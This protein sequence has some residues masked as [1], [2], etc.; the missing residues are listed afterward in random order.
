VQIRNVRCESAHA[1]MLKIVLASLHMSN[2]PD[3]RKIVKFDEEVLSENGAF[4]SPALR[5]CV[6]GAVLK[7]PLAGAPVGTDLAPLVDISVALGEALTRRALA[8]L[9]EAGELRAYS[10]AAIVGTAGDL[11][12]GAAM[13]HARIGMAMRSTIK[14][15]R[16]LIP[17]NAKVA[18]A[19]TTI[20]VIFG[21]IDEGWDLDA[22]DTMPIAV[23]DAPRVDE[24]LLLVGYASGPR[25][26]ARSRGPDQEDVDL[27][28]S[29]FG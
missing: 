19:G 9:G 7:N 29:S 28:L 3:I 24:I 18:C 4:V 12:H 17:G 23:A 15:G 16:V 27:L 11:E 1:Q 14:R 2:G 20:D 22:M 21:P 13:L 10:K 25:P 5:R 8:G 6:V 26:H